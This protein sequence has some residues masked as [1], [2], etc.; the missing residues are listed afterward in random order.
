MPRIEDRSQ[1]RSV[2]ARGRLHKHACKFAA[3]LQRGN[4]Q[5]IHSQSAG[6]THI[7]RLAGICD[8]CLL[9]GALCARCD[10]RFEGL[11]YGLR[12]F[13]SEPLVKS[14][15]ESAMREAGI[16]KKCTVK[17]RTR[18]RCSD[19]FLEQ[20]RRNG[21]RPM[22]PSTALCVHRNVR[23]SPAVRL[24]GRRDRRANL[25]RRTRTPG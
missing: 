14:R 22:R 17:S 20:I 12:V 6:E 11:R 4:Q 7:F 21:R 23:G 2:V 25:D 15:A 8:H 16:V 9:D 18:C 10:V 13:E 5:R 3:V 24:R 1:C 19:N